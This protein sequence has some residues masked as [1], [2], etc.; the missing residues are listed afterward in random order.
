MT[1]QTQQ[2]EQVAANVLDE[3]RTH[4]QLIRAC[5]TMLG[6]GLPWTERLLLRYGVGLPASTW[7]LAA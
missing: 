2:V 6:W 3:V 7:S 4:F 1:D 5:D